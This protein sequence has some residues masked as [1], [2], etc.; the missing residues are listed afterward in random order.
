[1]HGFLVPDLIPQFGQRFYG[2]V[3]ALLAQGKI[4]SLEYVTEGLE[5][6]AQALVDMLKGGDVGVGKPVVRVATE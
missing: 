3:P 1:M 4:K 5:N 6:A 2:E